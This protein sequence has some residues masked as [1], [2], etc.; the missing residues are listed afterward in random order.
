MDYIFGSVLQ[1]FKGFMNSL[2]LL[3]SY[4][5]TCQWFINL[6]RRIA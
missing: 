2:H 6:F 4:D 3:I 5:I 1:N